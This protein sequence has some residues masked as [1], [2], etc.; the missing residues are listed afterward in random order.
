MKKEEEY[1]EIENRYC[2]ICGNFI[3]EGSPSHRCKKK[4]IKKIDKLEKIMGNIEDDRTYD[5]K[6]EEFEK[7]Y[8]QENYYDNE[9]E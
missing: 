9:E 6:L 2:P 5:D 4:D 8:N 1:V 3:K 7:Y